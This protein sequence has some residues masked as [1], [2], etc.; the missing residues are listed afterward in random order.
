V[1]EEITVFITIAFGPA[2]SELVERSPPA[3]PLMKRPVIR[4]INVPAVS[5]VKFVG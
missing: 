5:I 2:K 3:P 4:I 1:A